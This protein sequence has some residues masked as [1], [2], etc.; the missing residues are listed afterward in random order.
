MPKSAQEP[1]IVGIQSQPVFYV[2]AGL[3]EVTAVVADAGAVDQRVHMVR[4][5]V[6]DGVVVGQRRLI[7]AEFGE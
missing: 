7:P 6:Q 3:A 2:S 4:V 1:G 5:E